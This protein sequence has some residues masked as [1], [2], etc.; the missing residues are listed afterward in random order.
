MT[1]HPPPPGAA[2]LPTHREKLSKDAKVKGTLSHTNT[3]LGVNQCAARTHDR[4]WKK[5]CPHLLD[6]GKGTEAA[7]EV[8]AEIGLD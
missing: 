3:P 2:F 8:L 6:Q 4:H 7:A 5:N 1:G